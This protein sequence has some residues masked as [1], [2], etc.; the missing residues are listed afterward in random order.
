MAGN[1]VAVGPHVRSGSGE[2]VNPGPLP[3]I[4]S[5]VAFYPLIPLVACVVS[6]L[7]AVRTW[8]REPDNRQM[9]PH[10]GVSA[11]TSAWAFCE[12]LALQ[13][14]SH[15]TALFWAQISA[16]PILPLAPV[17]LHAIAIGCDGLTPG[18]ARQ[19][20]WL[21]AACVPL[22]VLGLGTDAFVLGMVPTGH[23]WNT[24]PGPGIVLWGL[25]LAWAAV[26]MARVLERS[27]V[28]LD[29]AMKRLL[30]VSALLPLTVGPATDLL[31]PALG[32]HEFPR[33]GVAS[34]A[35]VGAMQAFVGSRDARLR[36]PVGV[37][38]AVLGM[39]PDGVLTVAPT[40]TIRSA[41]RHFAE[42]VGAPSERLVG[43]SLTDF[44][45]DGITAGSTDLRDFECV[46]RTASGD[47]LEVA[48]SATRAG[49]LGQT[50]A[51]TLIVRSL[52][53]VAAL[54]NRLLLAG[55]MAAVGGL[56]AGIAHELNTPLAYVRSNLAYLR[57]AT[58]R[59]AKAS[60]AHADPGEIEALG[61]ECRSIVEESLEGVERAAAIVRD[62]R[63]FSH[64]GDGD[65][66][67]T[68]LAEVIHQSV[69]LAATQVPAAVRIEVDLPNTLPRIPANGARLQQV[70]I[71]LIV[72]AGHA[73][74]GAGTIELSARDEGDEVVVTVRDDGAGIRPDDLERIFDPFFTTKP[75][76]IG[77][78]LGLAIAFAIVDEH[79]GRLEV[80]S[81]W[82]SGST[83][84]VRLPAG[85]IR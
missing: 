24:R 68:D 21:Y 6:A 1:G 60:R 12:V 78:G 63:A 83:F 49:S 3:P 57:E 85:V 52:R 82:G 42:L 22:L 11:L 47:A 61:D 43:R 19:L 53:E 50:T 59:M 40:G 18:I 74:E 36:L 56:A 2:T 81:E 23:G 41:N 29:P 72:N 77:T 28:S 84:T 32:I 9:W 70:L 62:V 33:L 25:M 17:A 37:T 44:L 10:V 66:A 7:V 20:R 14:R 48:V 35:F 4:D 73:I 69:P 54:R 64:A 13:A 67:P 79:G 16:V 34:V 46:L 5:N 31:L 58:E 26:G 45:P 76:G 8:M 55:R 27:T 51:H 38:S 30:T 80:T 75:V 15:E 39:L 65:L 71:N